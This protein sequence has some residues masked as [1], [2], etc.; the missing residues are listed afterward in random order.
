MKKNLK[1]QTI[2]IFIDFYLPGNRSGGSMRTIYNQT[3]HLDGIFDYRIVTRN[4][5]VGEKRRYK[6]VPSNKWTKVF[7]AEILYSSLD[8]NYFLFLLNLFKK[9]KFKT[10]YLNSFF[11]FYFTFLPLLFIKIFNIGDKLNIVLA[12]R[13]EFGPPALRYKKIQK[14]VYL[15]IFKIL[16]DQINVN[17]QASSV[18]ELDQIK[19]FFNDPNN[20]ISI[21]ED[22][23]APLKNIS[24]NELS[25][26]SEP[27]VLK[28]V[29]VSRIHPIKNIDF[30]LDCLIKLSNKKIFIKFTII[31]PIV[32]KDYWKKCQELI[33]KLPDNVKVFYLGN[34]GNKEVLD[35]VTKHELF[36]LPSKSENYGHVVMESLSCSVPVLV[37]DQTPWVTEGNYALISLELKKSKWIA[38]LKDWIKFSCEE[39]IKIRKESSNLYKKYFK[40][41]AILKKHYNLFTNNK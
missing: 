33:D 3:L 35:E 16:F 6:K 31:G 7:N 8:L 13:G 5:D 22:A 19:R 23:C 37:S 26:Y 34:L 15:K 29:T 30:F 12:P 20:T 25:I 17:W 14:V 21:V 1:I 11:S 24:P 2:L 27:H 38:I 36:I 18:V 4:Y 28:I 9:N 10:I 39:K 41:S 32:D 40:K